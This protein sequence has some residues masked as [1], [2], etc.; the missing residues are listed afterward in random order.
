[1]VSSVKNNSKGGLGGQSNLSCGDINVAPWGS[2]YPVYS[3]K[4]RKIYKNIECAKED[5]GDVNIIP[6][7][8]VIKCQNGRFSPGISVAASVL[9]E[10]S[11]RRDCYIY[12]TFPG[13]YDD[14]KPLKCYNN[15]VDTCSESQNFQV[16]EG[17]NVSRDDI[18]TLCTKSGFLSHFRQSFR[19]YANV[20]CHIC[21][22]IFY[23]NK[24]CKIYAED[25]SKTPLENGVFTALIDFNFITGRR[26]DDNGKKHVLPTVCSVIDVS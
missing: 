19:L 18:V 2:L 26:H 5:G 14:L 23:R 4:S 21:N 6:W 3:A 15:L 16:P 25:E 12:L 11:L 13:D 8:A 7:N 1:M 10:G 24:F 22:E 20:F 17:M 9:D